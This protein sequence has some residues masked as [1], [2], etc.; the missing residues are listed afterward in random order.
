MLGTLFHEWIQRKLQKRNDTQ[1]IHDQIKE[2]LKDLSHDQINNIQAAYF[3]L[4]KAC[5][6]QQK[7]A[8]DTW[9]DE[10]NMIVEKG[11]DSA[12]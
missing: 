3:H 5:K 2:L 7:D 11:N 4:Y 12:H 6:T 8:I 9:I 10:I 1:E